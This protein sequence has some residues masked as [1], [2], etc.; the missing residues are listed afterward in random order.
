MHALIWTE[1]PIDDYFIDT[2]EEIEIYDN[3]PIMTNGDPILKWY[4][5]V[6]ILNDD[7][8]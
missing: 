4:P 6:P 2:V 7:E 8:D 3:K 5:G 1:L